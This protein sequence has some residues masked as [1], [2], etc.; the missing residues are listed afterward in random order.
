MR[1]IALF[2][3]FNRRKD[4]SFF[5]SALARFGKEEE[6]EAFLS[7]SLSL[8]PRSFFSRRSFRSASARAERE[9]KERATRKQ[10]FAIER[11]FFFSFLLL[12]FFKTLLKCIEMHFSFYLE[13]KTDDYAY[14]Y[15]RMRTQMKR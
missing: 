7:L 8:L 11:S 14:I 4:V 5:N 1:A 6:E 2:F 13:N 9:R 12:S 3:R 10:F 15:V